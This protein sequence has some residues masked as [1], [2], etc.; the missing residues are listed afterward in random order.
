MFNILHEFTDLTLLVRY[1]FY[2]PFA[3]EKTLSWRL[4][5]L[6]NITQLVSAKARVSG[7][8]SS[9]RR[10]LLT[11][12]YFEAIHP[13]GRRHDKKHSHSTFCEPQW[14][15][16][17]R[18]PLLSS[19]GDDWN[20]KKESRFLKYILCLHIY[21]FCFIFLSGSLWRG[22]IRVLLWVSVSSW[23]RRAFAQPIYLRTS[24][25]F[26]RQL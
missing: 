8:E 12:S 15:T 22:V 20:E 21:M 2:C 19:K 11:A 16:L 13:G 3:D 26:P 5:D 6:F 25:G 18:V 10:R 23:V 17:W 7:P 14:K 9:V 4:C 1:H 24:H